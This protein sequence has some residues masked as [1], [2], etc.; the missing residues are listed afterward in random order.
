M[1]RGMPD[2]RD[3][4]DAAMEVAECKEIAKCKEVGCAGE[5]A[6]KRALDERRFTPPNIEARRRSYTRGSEVGDRCR[7]SLKP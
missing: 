1:R 4:K 5:G 2:A 3:E 6:A 7:P